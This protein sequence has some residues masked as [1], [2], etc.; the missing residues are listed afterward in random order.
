MNKRDK[1][2]KNGGKGYT[3][4]EKKGI[5]FAYNVKKINNLDGGWFLPFQRPILLRFSEVLYCII[6]GYENGCF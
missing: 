5:V 1:I 6:I 3:V 4:Y 2:T